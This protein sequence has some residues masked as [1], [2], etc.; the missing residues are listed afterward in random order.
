MAN[1]IPRG[2]AY[3]ASCCKWPTTVSHCR[4]YSSGSSN[5]ALPTVE[6]NGP[7]STLAPST[8]MTSNTPFR[9]S[10]DATCSRWLPLKSPPLPMAAQMELQVSWCSSSASLILAGLISDAFSKAI[11]TESNPQALNLGNND[12]LPSV[13]GAVNKNVFIPNFISDVSFFI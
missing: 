13:N 10:I 7:A 8:G 1:V 5:A 6:Y 9:Y 12:T 11:S 4:L 2:P 3:A